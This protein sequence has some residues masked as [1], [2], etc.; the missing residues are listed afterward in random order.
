[1]TVARMIDNSVYITCIRP[2]IHMRLRS[3]SG[4]SDFLVRL[5]GADVTM[6]AL[7]ENSNEELLVEQKKTFSSDQKAT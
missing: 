2:A 5:G 3:E 4:L 7:Y 6:D 1:M